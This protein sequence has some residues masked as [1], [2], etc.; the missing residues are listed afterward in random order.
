M[1]ATAPGEIGATRRTAESA[2]CSA[3]NVSWSTGPPAPVRAVSTHSTPTSRRAVASRPQRQQRAV[4]G[5]VDIL[6]RNRQR[7]LRRRRMNRLGQI[8][9]HPVAQIGRAAQ[10]RNAPASPTGGS[11]RNVAVNSEKNGTVC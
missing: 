4:I 6:Q 2:R 9:H 11:A 1:W 5:P 10:R 3:D 8:V 7:R